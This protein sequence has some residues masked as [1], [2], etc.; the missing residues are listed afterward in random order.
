LDFW[1]SDMFALPLDFD[2]S[3]GL[4]RRL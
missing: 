1:T 2:A 4:L 3:R